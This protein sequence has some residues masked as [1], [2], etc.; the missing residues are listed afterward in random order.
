MKLSRVV[1]KQEYFKD[2]NLTEKKS[3]AYYQTYLK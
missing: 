2:K 1:N 3:I